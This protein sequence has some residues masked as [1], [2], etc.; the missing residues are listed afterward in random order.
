MSC[1]LVDYRNY[2]LIW[3]ALLL[4]EGLKRRASDQTR[5]YDLGQVA[6]HGVDADTVVDRAS[7]VLE[8]APQA[9]APWVLIV[10]VCRPL[11]KDCKP[12]GSP[13]TTLYPL[14]NVSNLSPGRYGTSLGCSD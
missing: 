9:L 13:R 6:C 5:I 1:S 4:D 11:G 8:R 7:T 10:I 14:L 2:F 12:S 3:L